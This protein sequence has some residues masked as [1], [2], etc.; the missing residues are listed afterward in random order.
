MTAGIEAVFPRL[1]AA[2]YRVTSAQ[3]DV[4]NCIA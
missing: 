4:Y 1:R 3:D 2:N